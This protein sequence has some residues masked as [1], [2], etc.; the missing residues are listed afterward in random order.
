MLT[1]GQRHPRA[2]GAIAG[3]S[4]RDGDAVFTS[5]DYERFYQKDGKRLHHILDP[6]TGAP[7]T[8]TISVTVIHNDAALADAA[9]TALFVAGPEHWQTIA[10][11]LAV[12]RVMLID[13]RLNVWM[14]PQIQSQIA[15]LDDSVIVHLT[16][17]RNGSSDSD[18]P[19]TK[20]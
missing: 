20:N 19:E 18:T 10:R 7:A 16:K 13:D 5:G 3:V 1:V 4:A 14:T 15:I 8:K 2:D 12:K 9:A 11:Q 17:M 6:T